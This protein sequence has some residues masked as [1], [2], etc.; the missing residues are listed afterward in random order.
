MRAGCKIAGLLIAARNRRILYCVIRDGEEVYVP[1]CDMLTA[2]ELADVEERERSPLA[3]RRF[4]AL[5]RRIRRAEDAPINAAI[6]AWTDPK[7]SPEERKH[8]VRLA[9]AS[10]ER[11]SSDRTGSGTDAT[12][13]TGAGQR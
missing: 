8:L 10:C 2:A 11:G 13:R 3:R 1:R 5:L 12:I 7:V 4:G 9:L 6:K